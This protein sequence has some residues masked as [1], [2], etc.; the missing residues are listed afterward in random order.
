MT[1]LFTE[2]DLIRYI[3]GETSDLENAEIENALICDSELNDKLNG[4]RSVYE[5]LNRLIV[6]PSEKAMANIFNYSII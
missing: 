1:K 6:A 5:D 3:Y 4:L 2:N